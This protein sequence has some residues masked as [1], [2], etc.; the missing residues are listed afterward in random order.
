MSYETLYTCH[1]QKSQ[2][3]KKV[4]AWPDPLSMYEIGLDIVGRACESSLISDLPQLVLACMSFAFL[5]QR[6]WHVESQNIEGKTARFLNRLFGELP[7]GGQYVGLTHLLR[8]SPAL[9]KEGLPPAQGS[10]ASQPPTSHDQAGDG[11]KT[12]PGFHLLLN[13]RQKKNCTCHFL[14]AQNIPTSANKITESREVISI[15]L[16]QYMVV[17]Q[18]KLFSRWIWCYSICSRDSERFIMERNT[19]CEHFFSKLHLKEIMRVTSKVSKWTE[20][21]VPN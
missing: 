7:S 21:L 19:I 18:T 16:S 4:R 14:C 3:V 17:A 15:T 5:L 1:W 9:Y 20:K 12:G 11:E 6:G 2:S 13:N 10:V 8:L